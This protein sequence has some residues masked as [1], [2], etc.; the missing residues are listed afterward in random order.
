MP[1]N[2]PPLR[3]LAGSVW[4]DERP[5]MGDEIGEWPEKLPRPGSVAA[6]AGAHPDSS[7]AAYTSGSGSVGSGMCASMTTLSLTVAGSCPLPLL[8]LMATFPL[9]RRPAPAHPASGPAPATACR[10]PEL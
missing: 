10:L 1:A 8:R 2:P 6:A 9:P 5:L 4:N 3:A 7:S